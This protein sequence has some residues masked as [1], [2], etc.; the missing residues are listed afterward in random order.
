MKTLDN[1]DDTLTQK[2]YQGKKL[3]AV[4]TWDGSGDLMIQSGKVPDGVVREYDK[5]GEIV[6]SVTY[7]KGKRH[8]ECVEYN[9]EGEVRLRT[10]YKDDGLDGKLRE[11]N[12][13]G[14]IIREENYRKGV[15]DEKLYFMKEFY[16][17][18]SPNN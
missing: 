17:R 2:F 8:G 4:R 11:Y 12:D 1:G 5:S 10:Y 13:E 6:R 15:R 16:K 3:V 18:N 7:R 14:G 9:D